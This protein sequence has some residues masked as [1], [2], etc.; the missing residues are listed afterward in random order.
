MFA[1]FTEV[2]QD[3]PEGLVAVNPKYVQSFIEDGEPNFIT[4]INMRDGDFHEVKESFNEVMEEL[5]KC[6][7]K[8]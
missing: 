4:R 6:Q 8:E 2:Y 5:N 7:K 3:A 1:I